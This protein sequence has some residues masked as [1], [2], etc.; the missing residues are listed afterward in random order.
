ME[1][2][3]NIY[4]TSMQTAN[5]L[6]VFEHQCTLFLYFGVDN[7]KVVC[8]KCKYPWGG[9]GSALRTRLSRSASYCCCF[10]HVET[11]G[12]RSDYPHQDM[13][14]ENSALA[15]LCPSNI[16]GLFPL[17]L[18]VHCPQGLNGSQAFGVERTGDCHTAFQ[19]SVSTSV[20]PQGHQWETTVAVLSQYRD[21]KAIYLDALPLRRQLG[22]A[23]MH[24]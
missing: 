18:L 22:G 13:R 10:H 23:L 24:A 2:H 9:W 11:R 16:H 21:I 8:L 7:T 5:V 15:S 19:R 20:M 14:G 6:S 1:G 17:V 3:L 12:R 4:H